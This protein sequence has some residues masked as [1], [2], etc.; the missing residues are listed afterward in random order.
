MH[1]TVG[2]QRALLYRSVRTIRNTRY[3]GLLSRHE[4][5]F[6]TTLFWQCKKLIDDLI[7]RYMR[8]KKYILIAYYRK[9]AINRHFKRER[10]RDR[11][12]LSTNFTTN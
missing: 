12:K 1:F 4:T 3:T 5:G 7:K 6:D 8:F 11:N 9:Y 2:F 10:K